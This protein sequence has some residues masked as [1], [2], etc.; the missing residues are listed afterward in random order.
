MNNKIFMGYFRFFKTL[1]SLY[2]VLNLPYIIHLNIKSLLNIRKLNVSVYLCVDCGCQYENQCFCLSLCGLWVSIWE[3]MF[4]FI[5]VWI[6]GVNMRIMITVL[7]FRGRPTVEIEIIPE[8]DPCGLE[9][10]RGPCRAIKSR[11]FFNKNSGN[12]EVR[13]I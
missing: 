6:V 5:F 9:M 11:W 13:I 2:N 7:S 8:I 12:C 4:L 10:S 3:S 1:T